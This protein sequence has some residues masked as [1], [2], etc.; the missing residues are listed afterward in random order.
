MFYKISADLQRFFQL[1]TQSPNPSLWEKFYIVLTSAALHAVLLYRYQHWLISCTHCA[2]LRKTGLLLV[3]PFSFWFTA[4]RSI[5]ID[6]RATIGKGFYLSHPVG[7]ILGPVEIGENCNLGHFV[8]IGVGGRGA[9]RG[10]PRLGNQVWVGSQSVISGKIE[11]GDRTTIMPG[12]ILA[13]SVPANST[14]GGNPG[15]ILLHDT[16]NYELIFGTGF[17]LR[18]L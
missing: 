5:I 9:E 15:R 1:E 2:L 18:N 6:G 3:K 11:I 14:V 10:I 17:K 13:K 16:D 8:T 4:I 7:I 12:T